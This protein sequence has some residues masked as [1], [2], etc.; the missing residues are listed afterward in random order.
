MSGSHEYYG[1]LFAYPADGDTRRTKTWKRFYL[2]MTE[3]E[4]KYQ[5]PYMLAEAP[6]DTNAHDDFCDSLAMACIMSAS[7]HALPEVEAYSN[8]FIMSPR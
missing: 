5:G 2:Q 8:N 3:L 1:K 6:T 7:E 4:K